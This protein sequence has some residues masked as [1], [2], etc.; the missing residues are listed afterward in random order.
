MLCGQSTSHKR[1]SNE[2]KV[3]KR[4]SNNK[5]KRKRENYSM[6]KTWSIS[7]LYI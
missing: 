1:N 2:K 3:R 5:R 4:E 7:T 6:L